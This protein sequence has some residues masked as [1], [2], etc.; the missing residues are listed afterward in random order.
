MP[1]RLPA[2]LP[3]RQ[4]SLSP[5]SLLPSLPPSRPLTLPSRASLQVMRKIKLARC[6][7]LI[8]GEVRLEKLHLRVLRRQE[9][10]RLQLGRDG[11][12][13]SVEQMMA[14]AP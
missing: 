10:E 11:F 6:M 7:G 2:L 14:P 3:S 8:P 9:Q 5:P 13:M 4:P 1:A 12:P